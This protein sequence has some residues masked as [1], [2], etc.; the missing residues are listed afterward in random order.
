M[1]DELPAGLYEIVVTKALE[2]RLASVDNGLIK[3]QAL[4]SADAAD[5][6]ALLLARQVEQALDA[7]PEADRVAIGVE[8]AQRVDGA[9][10]LTLCR[11]IGIDPSP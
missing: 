11:R 2:D 3:R 9:L 8:V 6:I 1:A 5:R 7:V 10:R 4:R